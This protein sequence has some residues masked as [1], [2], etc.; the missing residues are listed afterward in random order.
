MESGWGILINTVM[1]AGLVFAVVTDVKENRIPNKI[2]FGMIA[3]GLALHGMR[4]GAA[5]I[6]FSAA[7]M[8]AGTAALLLP[9]LMGGMGGGDVKLMAGVGALG[10]LK[11]AVAAFL[12][13]AMTGGVMV[14]IRI[15]TVRGEAQKVKVGLIRAVSF[16]IAKTPPE[17]G[18]ESGGIPYAV[19]I[20]IGTAGSAALF[21]YMSAMPK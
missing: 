18:E 17:P 12:L 13:A 11:L 7:G 10:G 20:A 19:C 2:T 6:A 8:A 4:D 14:L 1:A 5:G 9:F 16:F 3:G 21:H 15:L